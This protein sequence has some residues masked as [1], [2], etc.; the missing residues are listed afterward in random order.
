MSE[1]LRLAKSSSLG[2]K[3]YVVLEW[4]SVLRQYKK[5]LI[6]LIPTVYILSVLWTKAGVLY[7]IG[8]QTLVSDV[9]FW[10]A[11]ISRVFLVAND[12]ICKL[13]IL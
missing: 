12:R 4:L 2:S 13:L 11:A 9:S 3:Y 7:I 5:F 1:I 6:D 10:V 8:N